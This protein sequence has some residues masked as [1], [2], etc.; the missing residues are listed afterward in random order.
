MG[1]ISACI[2]F[3]KKRGES[4]VTSRRPVPVPFPDLCLLAHNMIDQPT[5]L[6]IILQLRLLGSAN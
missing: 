3:K 1:F 2:N 4:S 6:D 5:I